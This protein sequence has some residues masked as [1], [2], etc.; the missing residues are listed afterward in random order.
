MSA[1]RTRLAT[2]EKAEAEKILQVKRAE[3]EAESKFL[4]GQGIARQRQAIVNGLRE[5]VLGF[6]H[7][8]P[9]TT[10]KD[11]MDMV[12]LTQYFDT[13]KDIGAHSKSN[14][15]FIPH[16]PGAV[17]DIADQIRSGW[18]QGAAASNNA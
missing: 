11:V 4:S 3:A 8:V 13:M 2:Q 17:S 18:L 10:P 14:A 12:M 16:G 9:G 7:E 6:S 5:S 1:A 15:I